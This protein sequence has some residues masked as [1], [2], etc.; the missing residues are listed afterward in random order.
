MK[1]LDR[2]RKRALTEVLNYLKEIDGRLGDDFPT[3]VTTVYLDMVQDSGRLPTPREFLGRAG[4][5]KTRFFRE[6]GN[7]TR[8][9]VLGGIAEQLTASLADSQ[10]VK[11]LFS[12]SQH[13]FISHSNTFPQIYQHFADVIHSAGFEPVISEKTPN[14]GRSWNPGQKVKALMKTCG[15]LVAVI[16]PDDSQ[17]KLPRLNIGHEVGLADALPIPIIYL[18]A[19]EAEL[20]SNIRPVYISFP[21]AHPEDADDEL[22]LNLRSLRAPQPE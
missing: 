3:R 4:R 10:D 1:P 16:T 22:I 18:K 6:N 20:P 8:A 7:L 14:Y 2:V 9:E 21:M 11:H 12:I 13:V 19:R 15:A 5:I 17:T